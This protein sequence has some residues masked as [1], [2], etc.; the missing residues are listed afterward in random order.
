M[1]NEKLY[2]VWPYQVKFFGYPNIKIKKKNSKFNNLSKTGLICRD[3]PTGT[4]KNNLGVQKWG[5]K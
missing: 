4:Y 3:I 2:T 1:K 5:S